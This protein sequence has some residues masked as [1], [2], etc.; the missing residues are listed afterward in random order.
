MIWWRLAIHTYLT[1]RGRG[2]LSCWHVPCVRRTVRR[3]IKVAKRTVLQVLLCLL[4]TWLCKTRCGFITWGTLSCSL[5]NTL[6][7]PTQIARFA[8]WTERNNTIHFDQQSQWRVS[9]TYSM[10]SI[11][12][13]ADNKPA[14]SKNS[15]QHNQSKKAHRNGYEILP[16]ELAQRT[17]FERPNEWAVGRNGLICVY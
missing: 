10:H 4:V 1:E 2:K 16:K 9:T 12:I 7:S 6:V 14:E 17:E 8:I 11:P 13:R 15:S 5:A 3:I